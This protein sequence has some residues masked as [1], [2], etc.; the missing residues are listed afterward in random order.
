MYLKKHPSKKWEVEDL[1][2]FKNN[3]LHNYFNF[4]SHSFEYEANYSVSSHNEPYPPEIDDL[5]RL[6]KLI[7]KRKVFNVWEFGIGYSTIIIADALNKNKSEFENYSRKNFIRRK[8]PFLLES[9]ENMKFWIEQF[10][11]MVPVSLKELIQ[12]H[13]S[14]VKIEYYNFQ[15]SHCYENLPNSFIPDFIYLDGPGTNEING[16]INGIDFKNN[17]DLTVMSNDL[18]KIENLLIPGCYILVDG[19]TNNA[20]FLKNNFKRNWDYFHDEDGDTHHFEL[21]EA[22]LGKYNLE[23]LKYCLSSADLEKFGI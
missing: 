17:S 19:R 15:I 4:E 23:Q 11:K 7:R 14:S 13:H 16:K 22:P 9:I 6:H 5:V 20:R 18:L 10:Q 2:Y 21:V 8:N 3:E 1:H 12:I